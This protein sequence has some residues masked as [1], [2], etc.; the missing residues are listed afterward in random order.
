M[1][2]LGYISIV[3]L[4]PYLLGAQRFTS[5]H[6]ARAY[7]S[8]ANPIAIGIVGCTITTITKALGKSA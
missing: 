8:A 7:Y 5:F 3:V 4:L 1:G 2:T 6:A